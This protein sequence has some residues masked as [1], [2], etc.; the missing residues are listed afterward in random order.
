MPQNVGSYVHFIPPAPPSDLFPIMY[1]FKC[2]KS[3]EELIEVL[4]FPCDYMAFDT[5][6]TGLNP[7]EVFIVGYSFCMDGKTAYYVP[8]KHQLGGLGVES[9]DLID[10]KMCNTKLVA[11]YNS[12]SDVRLVEYYGFMDTSR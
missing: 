10:D 1:S 6:A 9:L 2:I 12:R 4:S 8:V 7:E 11:M 5:E 3:I